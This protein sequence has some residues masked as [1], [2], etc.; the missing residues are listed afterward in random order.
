MPSTGAFFACAAASRILLKWPS[1]RRPVSMALMMRAKRTVLA[2]EQAVEVGGQRSR[3]VLAGALGHVGDHAVEAHVLAVL[4]R[5]DAGD[6]IGVQLVDLLAHDHAAAAA[7]D[8]DM[9]G[10]AF[11]S[12]GRSCI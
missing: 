2:L 9:T 1:L 4:G 11:A 5:V 6:A 10:A 7:E 3:Q 8:A 12:A